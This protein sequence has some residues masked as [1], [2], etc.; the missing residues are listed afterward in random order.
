MERPLTA[1][2]LAMLVGYAVSLAAGQILFKYAALQAPPSGAWLTRLVGLAL[3]PSFAAAV[4]LYAGLSV[5]WVWLLT[6]VPLSKAY[7]FV[8]LAFALT[9]AAGVVVF[10]EPASWRL[11]LGSGLILAGLVVIAG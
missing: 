2:Q 11:L 10:G 4:A 5:F 9:L 6:T 1:V 7:P 8:A 3:N